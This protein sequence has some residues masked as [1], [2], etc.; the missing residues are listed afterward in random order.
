MIGLHG[1]AIPMDI[2]FQISGESL[3]MLGVAMIYC[4]TEPQINRIGKELYF[5]PQGGIGVSSNGTLTA[6]T[7]LLPVA[8][9]SLIAM[10]A[11]MKPAEASFSPFLYFQF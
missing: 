4:A 5:A 11:V 7:S 9:V 6:A 8:V 2:A 1:F 3:V 10:L